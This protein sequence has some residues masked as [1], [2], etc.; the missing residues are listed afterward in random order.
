VAMRA[1]AWANYQNQYA[2]ASVKFNIDIRA[3]PPLAA[4]ANSKPGHILSA[5]SFG[6]SLVKNGPP[7]RIKEILRVLNFLAA[8]FGSDE[9]MV[10]RFG[11]KGAD[12]NLDARG[13]PVLTEQGVADIPGSP[14]QNWG[15]MAS[16]PNVSFSLDRAEFGCFGHTEQ[17][18]YIAAGISDPTVGQFSAT[19]EAKGAQLNLMIFDRVSAMAAGRAPL[20]DLDQLV[21]DW[22]SQGGDQ[23]RSEFE[24]VL[25]ATAA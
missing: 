8:P 4:D 14:G 22:R 12:Y 10:N 21:K 6:F 5:G 16:A 3:I 24:Q 2:Q 11:V 20:T 15:Y 9:Y 7:E 25:Q 23:I 1:N 18:A 19:D 17:A 13:N